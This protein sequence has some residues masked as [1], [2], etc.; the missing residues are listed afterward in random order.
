MGAWPSAPGQMWKWSCMG[1][2]FVNQRTVRATDRGGE[3]IP[4]KCIKCGRLDR[5]CVA[6]AELFTVRGWGARASS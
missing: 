4:V 1:C 2:G 3:F 6:P 5:R